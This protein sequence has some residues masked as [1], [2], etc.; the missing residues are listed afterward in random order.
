MYGETYIALYKEMLKEFFDEG[1]KNSLKKMNAIM[2]CEALKQK[3]P[4]TFS[5]PG[6]T[7][8]KKYIYRLFSK[9]ESNKNRG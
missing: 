3:F 6:E 8:I 5:I 1:A 2:I 7:E 4:D 9:L